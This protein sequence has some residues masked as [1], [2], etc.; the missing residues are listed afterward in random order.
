MQRTCHSVRRSKKLA[1]HEHSVALTAFH[2]NF[3][4]KH[5]TI[6]TTPALHAGVADNVWMMLDFV[7][8]LEREETKLG[9]RLIDYKPAASVK[10]RKNR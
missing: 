7:K 4:R 2:Y 8:M 3:V 6:K 5:H 9:G 1:N 10:A